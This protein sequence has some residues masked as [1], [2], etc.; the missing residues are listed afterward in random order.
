MA[1][2][3]AFLALCGGCDCSGGLG[4]KVESFGGS[5]KGK[6]PVIGEMQVQ[7]LPSQI[8]VE[9]KMKITELIKELQSIKE[10]EGDLE[11]TVTA[12]FDA[13]K[14]NPALQGGP[15]ESTC[16]N[17]II[18]QPSEEWNTRRLRLYW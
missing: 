10:K 3:W 7:I 4:S 15:F 17:L 18:Q 1:N 16:E 11:V 9:K 2:Y 14:Q 13:P 12:C 8:L 6:T 5:L